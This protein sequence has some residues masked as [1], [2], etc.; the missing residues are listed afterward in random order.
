M[1]VLLWFICS[2][3]GVPLPPIIS[4]R[5]FDRVIA[6]ARGAVMVMLRGVGALVGRSKGRSIYIHE[7]SAGVECSLRGRG[8][9]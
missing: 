8:S 5:G 7:R 2:D 6:F 1:E 9:C 4:E 3:A